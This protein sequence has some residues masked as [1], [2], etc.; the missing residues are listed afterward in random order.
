M[1]L[2]DIFAKDVTRPIDGVIKADDASNLASEVEEYV[3]TNE[4]A[5]G[6]EL[7]LE[8]YTNYTN[9][10]GVWISG[11][12]GSGKSHLLKM[13]SHLLGD[14]DGHILTRD[15][16]SASFLTKASG[17][18]LPGLLDKAANMP[19]KSLL[20]NVDQ[21]ATLIS[22]D[23]A[24]AL[25][26]VFVK[27]FEDS[28]GY[29]GSQ[30]HV[31][32]F[33]CDLDKRGQYGAFKSAYSRISGKA[34]EKGREESILEELNVE[35]AYAEISGQSDGAPEKILTKYRDDY[36]VS[37]E[38]FADDVS[39]WLET[40]K[41]GFHL[42]FFVDEVGQFIG[43]DTHL[44]LNLQTIA[45]SLNTKC[46]G[47]AWVIVTS[48]EDMDKVVGDRS[49]QQGNDFSKIQARFATRVKLTSADVEE[50]IR[51]R[52]LEKNAAGEQ[53]LQK[54][55][56][57][58]SA[59]FKTLFDFVDGAKTYRNFPDER[60]FVGTYP[61]VSYQFPLF[62]AAIEGLSD[63]NVFEGRNSSVGARSM[64][65]VVQHVAKDIGNVEIGTLATFDHMFA[66]ISASLKSAAQK[67]ILVAEKHLDN[68]LALKLLKALFLVKYVEGFHATA[69]N[70]TVL[71]Y[72]RFDLDLPALAKRVQEALTQLE[73]ETYAQRSGNKYEY[74]TND[75]QE[76]EGEIKEVD[77][78]GS[79][80]SQR[81]FKLISNDVIKPSKLRYAKNAQDFAFGFKLDD[82]AY[83]NQRDLTLHFISPAFDYSLHDVR[84]QSAG[85]DEL[86]VVFAGDDRLLSDLRLL[87]K[88]EKYIKLKRTSGLS[89]VKDRIL[90]SKS[91]LNGEREKELIE[92][93]RKAIGASTLIINATDISSSSQ[94][95]VARVTDGF[96][97]LV[98]RTFMQLSLL[99]N[100][101]YTEQQIAGFANPN[102][103]TLL[104]DTALSKLTIA[105]DEVE[106]YI[107]QQTDL[108]TNVTVKSIVERFEAKPYGWYLAG[109]LVSVAR[110]MGT[111]KIT[112]TLDGNSVKRS[113]VPG[114]LRNTQKH[115]NQIV[116]IQKQYDPRQVKALRDFCQQYFDDEPA[117]K[118]AAE[119]AR[120]ASGKLAT[121]HHEL[122]A[123]LQSTNYPFMQ[124]LQQPIDLLA[125]VVGHPDEWY[126]ESLSEH[127]DALLD[128]KEH[129]VDP[130]RNFASGGQKK[131]YD[132][133][134][135]LITVQ[136]SNLMYLAKGKD[137]DLLGILDDPNAF[138][139]NQINKLK[140]A[141]EAL[142][143]ALDA[144]TTDAR[145]TEIIK[146][147]GR[148]EELKSSADFERAT[149]EA[150][151]KVVD[152][153]ERVK[154]SIESESRIAAMKQIGSDFEI[155]TYPALLDLLVASPR[156]VDLVP[157]G[158][159]KPH[160]V[161]VSVKTISVAYGKNV[162]ADEADIDG[163]LV[164][165]KAQ[166]MG[167]VQDGKRISL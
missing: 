116:R 99:G 120:F 33:E 129:V 139:G 30:G 117:P 73:A 127:V 125:S 6:L 64:L 63:H 55:Y 16:V 51:K 148:L 59:N 93:V 98:S 165:Y 110:L 91:A 154:A 124:A 155:A 159:V 41:P 153:V 1:K 37:I 17:A 74:L 103:A 112:I 94:E 101:V 163:Y 10:N 166:L 66:G 26:K 5:K 114:L 47:R 132:D 145:G 113:E 141:T 67:S 144:A 105:A 134:V 82:Q 122:T 53:A 70:L 152:N 42:N 133:A 157:V 89:A 128:A 150:C 107:S 104:D 45:E 39:A 9:A 43:S 149:D 162:L 80:V 131:I 48:Q 161:T 87:I 12:F 25:L 85:R 77:I 8:A 109:I 58:Q 95:A 27:V 143:A 79:E 121:A 24:D 88:T 60:L 57:D 83:G 90:Q 140:N 100:V 167:A 15:E 137:A 146:M 61:F 115:P 2:N 22:K 81:L 123:M 44:M 111:S 50:V 11:F 36:A 19:A 14:V 68:P 76:I 65:G 13:L 108:G 4:V 118:D 28:R 78:D 142:R 151:R 38:D 29:F 62:Q 102:E 56:T 164:A 126:L 147:D 130:I 23:Q 86:R 7:M 3:L 18:F 69:R 92:R 54:L 71:V 96:Q 84:M 97:D 34:W 46:G 158:P 52:L 160:V 106:T 72:D 40:Q 49:K 31:A 20:F 135:S 21:K 138:R 119:L 156:V 35:K 75:E 136:S 32:R